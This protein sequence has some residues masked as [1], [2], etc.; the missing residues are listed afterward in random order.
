[1]LLPT[2]WHIHNDHPRIL[3]FQVHGPDVALVLDI[4]CWLDSAMVA[5]R[6][7]LRLPYRRGKDKRKCRQGKAAKREGHR[8]LFRRGW[9]RRRRT[10]LTITAKG[11]SQQAPSAN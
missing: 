11:G 9:E 2:A 10:T 4:G 1:D 5:R 7:E 8:I 3:V 6:R